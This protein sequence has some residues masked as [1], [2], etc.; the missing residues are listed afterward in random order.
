MNA[1]QVATIFISGMLAAG[2]LVTS[3][4]FLKFWRQTGDRLFAFF[5][6]AFVLLFAQRIALTLASDLVASTSWYYG[7]RLLAFGLIIVAIADKNRS[8]PA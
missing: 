3:L 5:A 6:A 1:L 2:Y 8:T 4:F 7:V